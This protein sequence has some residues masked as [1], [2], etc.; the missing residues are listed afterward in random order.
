MPS[1]KPPP[2]K[3]ATKTVN[4]SR[5]TK[6]T[7]MTSAEAC[8]F[9]EIKPQ[10]LYAY[11]SRGLLRAELQPGAQGHLYSRSE[12]ELLLAR[13]R[14]RAGHGPTAA[15][16]MRWGEPILDSAITNIQ[17]EMIY[18]RGHA[19]SDLIRD[20]IPF[21]KVAE[22]LWSGELPRGEITW[23]FDDPSSLARN[24]ALFKKATGISLA[25]HLSFHVSEVALA[26]RDGRD[27]LLDGCLRKARH[28]I[29]SVSKVLFEKGIKVK[30]T[31]R[32]NIRI[33]EVISESLDMELSEAVLAAVDAALI[34]SADHE[35]NASTFAAR[36]AA[37]TGADLYSSILA[38]LA[39]FSGRHHGLS[40]MD[41]YNFVMKASSHKN[42]GKFIEEAL[43]SG[44]A[45][46]G[47]GHRLYPEGDPRAILLMDC[48]LRVAGELGE[49]GMRRL[50]G[51]LKLV[52]A[53]KEQRLPP[54]NLDLGLV[55]VALVLGL[56]DVAAVS[57]FVLGRIA[58]WTAHVIEQR[59]QGF[60][61]R[62][63]ARYV[64]RGPLVHE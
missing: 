27:E 54:P 64:G 59:Q 10:T 50:D 7:F 15:S 11:V 3:R 45:I 20:R 41:T 17:S 18:Y 26:D 23:N 19:L 39:A 2:R 12:L 21:E 31:K 33:A 49:E 52:S 63:R 47:F 57:F 46:P 32:P 58:G 51:L 8:A 1:A 56:P 62:P 53:A 55:A 16:A 5:D 43:V 30:A 60:L 34:A 25:R 28:L 61:L 6:S 22:L 14:A 4:P 24:R 42:L 48:A 36:V 9:L 13:S 40:P 29:C 35:L 44:R 37:S 38:G